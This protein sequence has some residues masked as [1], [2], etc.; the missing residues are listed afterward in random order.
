M[1][2]FL[3]LT[4][5]LFATTLSAN[6]NGLPLAHTG[7]F[8]ELTCDKAGCHRNA[9]LMG[10]ASMR[11]EVG[12]YVPGAT[13]PVNVIIES[14]SATRWG[15]QLTARRASDPRLPAG[16]LEALNQF[17]RVR[18][19]D[20][21]PTP[22][23][24][25]ELQ[26]ATHTSAAPIGRSRVFTFTINWT[27]PSADV[28]NVVL[29][30]AALAGDNDK[31]TNSD[32]TVTS[33]ATSLFAPTNSPSLNRGGTVSAASLGRD[34]QVISPE[35]LISLFGSNL[36]GPDS[37]VSTGIDDLDRGF[38]P[39]ELNRLSLEFRPP[40]GLSPTLGRI[41]FVSP[42]QVNAQAPDFP[43]SQSGAIE[44]T[45]IINRGKAANEVR[46]N[47]VLVQIAAKVPAL[48]TFDSSGRN[49]AAAVH[50]DG[51]PIAA[52]DKIPR[53]FPAAPNEIILLFGTGFGET[54][55][56]LRPGERS[57]GLNPLVGPITVTVGGI[58]LLP[59]EIFYAGAAPH[60][61]GLTQFNVRIPPGL[62][63]GDHI[64]TIRCGNFISQTEVFITV[65]P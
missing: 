14:A 45:P 35:S 20:G 48:F 56:P 17:S 62:P 28:G 50:A 16:T 60:F 32:V 13:Q 49:D 39:T 54:R 65:G 1:R 5:L 22:C 4:A 15:Y 43:L 2:V 23:R 33:L 37:I 9:P 57:T 41:L 31:G 12:P 36:S 11:I 30:A 34:E 40:G 47:T 26:Y 46:G 64:V 61:V 59:N 6:E 42:T 58:Q 19:A 8:G 27:A 38:I 29:T 53:S 24:A 18:C 10:S 63:P 51:R 55:T 52:L 3:A 21:M 7:A 25:D 44:V